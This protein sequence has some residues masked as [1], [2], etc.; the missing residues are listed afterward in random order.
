MFEPLLPSFYFLVHGI[1]FKII[2]WCFLFPSRRLHFNVC[3]ASFILQF[4]IYY[5]FLQDIMIFIY[6]LCCGTVLVSKIIYL[7]GCKE[8]CCS[9][10]SQPSH[11]EALGQLLHIRHYL[12]YSA[13]VL[14]C[15]IYYVCDNTSFDAD[16]ID[17]P[18]GTFCC[19]PKQDVV[20]VGG[21]LS[22]PRKQNSNIF[23]HFC[24]YIMVCTLFLQDAN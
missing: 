8:S 17:C 2:F 16:T 18:I 5:Y 19:T 11:L 13:L 23:A 15:T 22:N 4:Y 6:D 3:T 20:C 1:D 24:P 21:Q 10:Q 7:S 14:A 12:H 9:N